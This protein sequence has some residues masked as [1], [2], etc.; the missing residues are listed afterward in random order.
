[1]LREQVGL[2]L[3]QIKGEAEFKS[4]HNWR[5]RLTL[6]KDSI[7]LG[8]KIRLPLGFFKAGRPSLQLQCKSRCSALASTQDPMQDK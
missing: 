8:K 7:T 3:K 4:K 6:E 1:M 2:N 5:A